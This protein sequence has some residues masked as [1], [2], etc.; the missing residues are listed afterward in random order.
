MKRQQCFE[1]LY[2]MSLFSGFKIFLFFLELLPLR[3]IRNNQGQ[4]GDCSR[5]KKRSPSYLSGC[6]CL[7]RYS[8]ISQAYCEQDSLDPASGAP[9]GAPPV[10]L[11]L[12]RESRR[13]GRVQLEQFLWAEPV[14]GTS[15]EGHLVSAQ[16]H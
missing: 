11:D 7:W 16:Q 9:A 8:W 1:L 3:A 13:C 4:F 15:S 14:E 10:S 6:L 5:L 12:L 2:L